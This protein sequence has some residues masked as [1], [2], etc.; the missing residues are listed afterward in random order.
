MQPGNKKAW[1]QWPSQALSLKNLLDLSITL[2]TK[3]S[4]W[5]VVLKRYALDRKDVEFS[6]GEQLASLFIQQANNSVGH[7]RLF[8]WRKNGW[9]NDGIPLWAKEPHNCRSTC[10]S[11]GSWAKL[12]PRRRREATSGIHSQSSQSF[13]DFSGTKGTGT[14]EDGPVHLSMPNSIKKITNI[15]WFFKNDSMTQL[16][17]LRDNIIWEFKLPIFY[18]LSYG[19][20]A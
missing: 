8:T 16:R 4:N 19:P 13:S 3:L 20:T 12:Y 7:K 10:F 18:A 15:R 2:A 14:G 17:L 1:A 6:V 5:M 11:K 9:K